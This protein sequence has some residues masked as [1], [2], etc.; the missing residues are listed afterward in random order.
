MRLLN[1]LVMHTSVPWE[2]IVSDA[3]DG[4]YNLQL[5]ENVRI[6]PERPRLGCTKG[7]N[8]AFREASGEWVIWL[9]DDC[10][11]LPDYA[12]AAINFMESHPRIGLGALHYSEESDLF[13]VNSAW[14]CIYANFGIFR[15]SIGEQVGF[16]DE[17]LEMYG[18][19]N[20]LTLRVLL[21]GLGVAGI[22]DSKV[23]HHSVKD[24]HR[25]ENQISRRRDNETLTEKYMSSRSE[26]TA[27]YR[28]NYV[29]DGTEPWS[30]GRRPEAVAIR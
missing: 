10:E 30:H 1:S 9:N 22:A 23:I 5:P 3:S 21:A 17:D 6:L 27:I 11:V 12:A 18:C 29:D 13:H 20:S 2:L 14:G 7:Y 15:R 24:N 28:E 16:F 19:D 26:W 25:I 8:R 4:P